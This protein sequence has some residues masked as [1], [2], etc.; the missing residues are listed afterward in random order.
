MKVSRETNV[1]APVEVTSS[2]LPDGLVEVK[3][4]I[5]SNI[6][7]WNVDFKNRKYFSKNKLTEDFMSMVE[8]RNK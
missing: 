7:L 1:D 4:K 3:A 2:L 5:G 8:K 6:F